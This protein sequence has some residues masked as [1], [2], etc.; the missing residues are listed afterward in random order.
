MNRFLCACAVAFLVAS[1]SVPALAQP[2]DTPKETP[3]T[4][5]IPEPLPMGGV[6]V[7]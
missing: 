7:T 4:K 3:K 5:P 2:K 1:T 6:N